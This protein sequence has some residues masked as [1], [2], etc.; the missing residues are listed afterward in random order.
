MPTYAYRDSALELRTHRAAIKSVGDQVSADS[1]AK[2][3][4]FRAS[5]KVAE[6]TSELTLDDFGGRS[7]A[8]GG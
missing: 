3:V 1:D 5:A 4:H 6:I 7:D 8:L 2:K